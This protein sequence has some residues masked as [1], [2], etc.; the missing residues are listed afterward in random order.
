MLPPVRTPAVDLSDHVQSL[1]VLSL[2]VS[3][4]PSDEPGFKLITER[5]DSSV[6]ASLPVIHQPLLP[7]IPLVAESQDQVALTFGHLDLAASAHRV[8]VLC[9]L[10]LPP[11]QPS[12]A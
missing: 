11:E 1:A 10:A 9:R 7:A 5:G 3:D 8:G 2:L 12:A 4:Q 6:A